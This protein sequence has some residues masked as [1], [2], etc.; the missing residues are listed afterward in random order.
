[1]RRRSKSRV[2]GTREKKEE[3]KEDP[4][5]S[6][7]QSHQGALADARRTFGHKEDHRTS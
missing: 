6:V 1:M 4:V 3:A 5:Q 2:V 7:L